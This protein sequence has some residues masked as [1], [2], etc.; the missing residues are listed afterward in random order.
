MAARAAQSPHALKAAHVGKE[1]STSLAHCAPRLADLFRR[2]AEGS[3][4]CQKRKNEICSDELAPQAGRAGLERNQEL[5][6]T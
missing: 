4:R 3:A 5:G 1:R 6:T 2:R